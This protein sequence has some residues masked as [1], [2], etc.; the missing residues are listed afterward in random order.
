MLGIDQD[1]PE[2]NTT[3]RL[4]RSAASWLLMPMPL[5]VMY[6]EWSVG[7]FGLLLAVFGLAAMPWLRGGHP[8]TSSLRNRAVLG[9]VMFPLL[10]VSVLLLEGGNWATA[11]NPSRFLIALPVIVMV[12]GLV[13]SPA[14][15]YHAQVAGGWYVGLFGMYQVLVQ[16]IIPASGYSNPNKFGYVAAIYALL[17]IAAIRL[18]RRCRPAWWLLAS[19]C[20]MALSAMLL[21]GTRGTWIAFSV[22]MLAWFLVS[23]TIRWRTRGAVVAAAGLGA[24]VFALI[25]GTVVQQRWLRAGSEISEYLGG[26]WADSSIGERF[27]LW[28][29]ALI[30]IGDHPITGVGLGNYSKALRELVAQGRLDAQIAHHGH[31]HNEYLNWFATGGIPAFVGVC[32]VMLLPLAY[33]VRHARKAGKEHVAASPDDSKS[34]L[35][36]ASALAGCLVT[37]ATSIFCLFD[38]FFYIHFS[39]VYYAF[40]VAILIGFVEGSRR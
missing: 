31:A 22:A 4:L 2:R 3:T 17:C 32:A 11:D 25:E 40:T 1:I 34:G 28:R 27:E 20:V 12:A 39:T 33:F 37:L 36:R 15:F 5:F 8:L 23:R 13:P 14:P 10:V 30:M 24:I 6:S 9:F 16:N 18:D 7:P 38:A 19:G 26:H 35:Y 21:S 29:G